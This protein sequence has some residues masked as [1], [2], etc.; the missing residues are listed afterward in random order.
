[1][2]VL[3]PTLAQGFDF[4]GVGEFQWYALHVRSNF[5]RAVSAV[6]RNKGFEEFLPTYSS[7]RRWSDRMKTDELPMFPGYLFCRVDPLQ[8]MPVLTTNG[9]VRIVGVGKT[10]LPVA[11]QELEAVWRIMHSDVIA[12]PWPYISA[13][14]A[15]AI[16]SGP[17][18]GLS[19]ILVE[20]KDRC[21]L[22]VS[23]TLLQRSVAVEIDRE[24]AEPLRG[25][26]RVIGQSLANSVIA[27]RKSPGSAA[28]PVVPSRSIS[29][30]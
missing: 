21:R 9:V 30:A 10:P 14:E 17:L 28:S 3:N 16:R 23:V 24:D 7:R 29:H 13:G 6:L 5:E 11:Q 15:V 18:E 12:N 20:T 25:F 22:V 4:S 2:A 1:M 8:R 26:D 27:A 19:G